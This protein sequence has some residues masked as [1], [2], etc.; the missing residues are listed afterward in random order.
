VGKPRTK[1]EN[2]VQKDALQ[3]LGIR[4]WKKKKRAGDGEEWGHL[5]RE[6]RAQKGL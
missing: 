1:W 4:Y 6:A 2:V 5:L 3:I